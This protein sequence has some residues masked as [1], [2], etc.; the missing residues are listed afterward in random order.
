MLFPWFGLAFAFEITKIPLTGSPPSRLSGSTA[1]YDELKNQIITF[2]GFDYQLNQYSSELKTFNL[3]SLE[4]GILTV[5]SSIVP[6]G[7]ESAQ[8]YLREDRKL[9]VFFGSSSIGT[10]NEVFSY[11]LLRY[12]WK[13]EELIGYRMLGTFRPGF[14]PFNYNSTNYVGI[15]GGLTADGLDHN[16]YL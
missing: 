4:W 16:L 15:F 9:F 13:I 14:T 12:V 5:H 8:M 10:S 3:T 1:V 2:G 11:D 7:L 6:P